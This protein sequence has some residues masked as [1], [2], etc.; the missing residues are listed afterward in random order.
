MSFQMPRPNI[1]DVVQWSHDCF[2]FTNPAIGWVVQNP[3]QS[4]VCILTFSPGLGFVERMG[5]HHKDDPALKDN[6]GWQDAGCWAYTASQQT[7]N[8][9]DSLASQLVVQMARAESKN[10]KS[11]AAS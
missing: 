5:C 6:P 11:T 10:G 2:G 3:G 8:K 4:T 7:I 9:M 1:G